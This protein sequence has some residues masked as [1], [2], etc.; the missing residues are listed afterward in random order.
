MIQIDENYQLQNDSNN[1]I[2]RYEKEMIKEK[3]GKP[4][5]SKDEWYFPTISQ[6]LKKYI[7]QSLKNHSG[8]DGIMLA[9]QELELKIDKIKL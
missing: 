7:D 2:L 8:V 9:I 4:Y 3:T 6:A 5:T 1:W